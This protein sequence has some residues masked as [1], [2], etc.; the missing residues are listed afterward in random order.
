MSDDLADRTMTLH[1]VIR[2]PV[3]VVWGAWWNPET[4]PRW[5]GPGGFSAAGPV[6]SPRA[7]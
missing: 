7:A 3:A 4:L 6:F 2:A 1:R 5:W